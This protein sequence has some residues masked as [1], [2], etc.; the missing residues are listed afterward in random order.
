[1]SNLSIPRLAMLV[2]VVALSVGA[3]T[4][5]SSSKSTASTTGGANGLPTTPAA[6]PISPSATAQPSIAPSSTPPGGATTSVTT[7]TFDGDYTGS[8]KIIQCAGSGPTASAQVNA[9]FT[10][11]SSYPGTFGPTEFGFQGPSTEFDS[12]FL[13]TPLDSDGNGFVLDGLKATD[14]G[15]GKSVTMHGTLRCPS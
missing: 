10:G 15:S 2:C 14:A 11:G 1:M 5:C 7:V 6:A 8:V 9:T 4:G 3:A 13:N 12:G